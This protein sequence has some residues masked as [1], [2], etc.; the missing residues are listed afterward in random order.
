MTTLPTH[1]GDLLCPAGRTE[2]AAF[3]V[4]L[5]GSELRMTGQPELVPPLAR[6]LIPDVEQHGSTPDTPTSLRQTCGSQA[7]QATTDQEIA[8]SSPAERAPICP[9]QR[10]TSCP[11]WPL[12]RSWSTRPAAVTLGMSGTRWPAC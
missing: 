11:P 7:W 4:D 6:V 5:V 8:G 1:R 2:W 10:L 3:H 12:G 9:G